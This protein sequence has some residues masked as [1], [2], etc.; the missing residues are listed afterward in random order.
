MFGDRH[1]LHHLCTDFSTNLAKP[2]PSE[3]PQT[4][5]TDG[6]RL[7]VSAWAIRLIVMLCVV[8]GLPTLSNVLALPLEPA[9]GFTL[10]TYGVSEAGSD[11]DGGIVDLVFDN[12]NP[13]PP[14]AVIDE[15]VNGRVSIRGSTDAQGEWFMNVSSGFHD[16]VGDMTLRYTA[17]FTKENDTDTLVTRLSNTNFQIRDSGSSIP[18]DIEAGFI[19]QMELNDDLVFGDKISIQGRAGPHNG[20]I[21]IPIIGPF[22]LT[23]GTNFNTT[24]NER[25]TGTYKDFVNLE[26]VTGA[27]YEL[28]PFSY[29]FDLSSIAVGE[30]FK[31]FWLAHVFA[32]TQGGETFASSRLWD[33]L[34]GGRLFEVAPISGGPGP[35]PP[36][37][38]PIPPGPIPPG[39]GP[40]PVPEP[41]TFLLLGTGL[42][43]L[44][45]YKYRN[46]QKE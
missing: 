28:D 12:S 7:Q 44:G 38:G 1:L 30:T 27:S 31:I 9:E 16:G 37:P 26:N 4:T 22:T 25:F 5:S 6:P 11:I 41:G 13:S 46:R 14:P 29:E 23:E 18:G 35:V 39:P 3:S 19:L 20:K 8:S 15:L 40:A 32:E 43:S 21:D 42:V 17:F 24:G 10:L 36:I 2:H 33:P 45:L 34:S